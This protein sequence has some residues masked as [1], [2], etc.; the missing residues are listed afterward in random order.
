MD[1]VKLSVAERLEDIR[2]NANGVNRFGAETLR[3]VEERTGISH[4][5]ISKNETGTNENL[6]KLIQLAQHYGV[7]M[8]YICG[9][10]DVPVISEDVQAAGKTLGLSYDAIMNIRF[11]AERFGDKDC[12]RDVLDSILSS[13][14]L[15]VSVAMLAAERKELLRITDK[16]QGMY[17]E[18]KSGIPIPTD[19]MNENLVWCSM[20]RERAEYASFK[21]S[22]C[23]TGVLN[24][25][26]ADTV[27]VIDLLCDLISK[28]HG[29][30]TEK[31]EPEGGATWQL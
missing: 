11:L 25:A 16:A 5:F 10:S 12:G 15:I 30:A 20:A 6:A 3:E 26:L 28:E 1:K 13:E 8:D 4:S 24:E 7:S 31:R 29:K 23:F 17:E 18:I 9:L 27:E 14:G 2:K 19:K 22:K 21:A